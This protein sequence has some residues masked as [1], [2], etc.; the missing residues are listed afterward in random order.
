M[1]EKDL[2]QH[3]QAFELYTQGLT[4]E[5]IASQLAISPNTL[6]YWKSERCKCTCGFHGWVPFKKKLQVQVPQAIVESVQQALQPKLTAH[7]MIAILESICAN[8][9]T[10]GQGLAPRTWRELLETFKLILDLKKIYGAGEEEGGFE[11]S[12]TQKITGR[13]DLHTL[14]DQFMHKVEKE[15]KAGAV[16]IVG[17]LMKLSTETP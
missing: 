15:D 2:E 8:A 4:L 9:L 3:K 11:I 7:Q 17:D 16:D 14:I 5:E 1:S 6:R 10:S 13:M 12:Q